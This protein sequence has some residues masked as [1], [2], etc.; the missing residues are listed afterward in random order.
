MGRNLSP[1]TF[2]ALSLG[3]PLQQIAGQSTFFLSHAQFG[4]RPGLQEVLKVRF[5]NSGI[6][7]EGFC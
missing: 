6:L 2:K 3:R 7:N 1:G 4:P 5:S